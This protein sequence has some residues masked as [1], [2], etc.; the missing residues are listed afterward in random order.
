MACVVAMSAQAGP[1]FLTDDPEPVD[2]HHSEVNFI[3]QQT[4]TS[5]G[6]GGALSGTR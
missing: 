5:D 1:P 4:R 2:L 3:Y 6:R